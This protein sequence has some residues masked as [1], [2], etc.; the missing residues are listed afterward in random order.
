M[1]L[2]GGSDRDFIVI[3]ENI[4]TT[5]VVLR[6]GARVVAEDGVE[7]VRYTSAEGEA[8]LL[9]IPEAVKATQDYDEG[10]VKHVKIA[11][12]AAMSDDDG[13]AARGMAYLSHL[14]VGQ[15]R[16]G[17]DFL[18]INVDEISVKP[19]AQKAAMAWLVV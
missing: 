10:R 18:D 14:V 15:E 8:R 16:A 5:R 4:H 19:E 6:K 3:G 17:A 13:A 11:L 12:E 9:P 1:K 2:G 7:G